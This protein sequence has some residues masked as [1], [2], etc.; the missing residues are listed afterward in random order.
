MKKS[1]AVILLFSILSIGAEQNFLT[2]KISDGKS[3]PQEIYYDRTQYNIGSGILMSVYKVLDKNKKLLYTFSLTHDQGKRILFISEKNGDNTPKAQTVKYDPARAGLI[4]SDVGNMDTVFNLSKHYN[5]LISFTDTSR[6][7]P[8]LNKIKTEDGREVILD[9]LSKLRIRKHKELVKKIMPAQSA[10]I[11]ESVQLDEEGNQKIEQFHALLKQSKDTFYAHNAYYSA[12]VGRLRSQLETNISTLLKGRKVSEETTKYVGARKRGSP[13]GI[14]LFISNGNYYDGNF[15]EGRFI[16][17]TVIL[18]NEA[19]E[20]CGGYNEGKKSGIG[21]LKY[22]NGNFDLGI[23]A[24][25]VLM[26]GASLDNNKNGEIFFG[27][28]LE[29]QRTGYGELRIKNGSKYSGE[30]TNGRLTSGYTKEVDPF[31]FISYSRVDKGLKTPVDSTVTEKLFN[32]LLKN[33]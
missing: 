6:D 19:Y 10:S 2:G 12:T 20:Y 23:F 21:W 24:N 30:F 26:N 5:Y 22:Q 27:S 1:F 28:Y 31:G 29:G 7:Y 15:L 16:S 11:I 3:A 13:E 4:F 8:I 9:P 25:D 14:G 33:N 18:K 17:G 32:T